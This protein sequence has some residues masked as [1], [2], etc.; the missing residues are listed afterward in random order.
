M[1]MFSTY[2]AWA[3]I[4]SA[5]PIGSRSSATVAISFLAGWRSSGSIVR[6]FAN[7]PVLPR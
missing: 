6:P 3:L 2:F 1:A 7:A 4:D 5:C